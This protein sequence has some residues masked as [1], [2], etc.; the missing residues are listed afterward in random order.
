MEQKEYFSVFMLIVQCDGTLINMFGLIF[1]YSLV[2]TLPAADSL[3][4]DR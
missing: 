1:L 2:A 3:S 4:Y